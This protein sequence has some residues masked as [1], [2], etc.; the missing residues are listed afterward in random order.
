MVGIIQMT[1]ANGF[2][3]V[4]AVETEMERKIRSY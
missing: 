2:S 3:V 4:V 1:D